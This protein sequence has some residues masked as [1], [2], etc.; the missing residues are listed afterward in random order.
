MDTTQA[1]QITDFLIK[2][3]ED[4]CDGDG[5][6]ASRR[7]WTELLRVIKRSM[8]ATLDIRRHGLKILRRRWRSA[9]G[10][11]NGRRK[12]GGG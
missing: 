12:N 4:L 6:T 2:V 7:H 10:S 3:R 1:R 5:D 11:T 8:H 9:R